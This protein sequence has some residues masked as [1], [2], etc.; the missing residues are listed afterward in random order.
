MDK[1]I[2]NLTVYIPKAFESSNFQQQKDLLVQKV[3]ERMSSILR[4]IEKLAT[5]A[6]FGI[7]QSGQRILLIPLKDNKLITPDEYKELDIEK[8][9]EIDSKRTKLASEIDE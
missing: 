4:E 6:G 9:E 5:D 8:R 7:Q 1:L 3:N 2:A